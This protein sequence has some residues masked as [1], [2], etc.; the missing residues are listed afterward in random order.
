MGN[1]VSEIRNAVSGWR[2]RHTPR[3]AP[4]VRTQSEITEV[5]GRRADGAESE[6][7]YDIDK[8]TTSVC[9]HVFI[10]KK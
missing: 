5:G 2:N 7:I 8:Q 3:R 6:N 1:T 10:H 9:S 4:T